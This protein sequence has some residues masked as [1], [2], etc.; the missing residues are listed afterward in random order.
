M[1]PAVYVLHQWGVEGMTGSLLWAVARFLNRRTMYQVLDIDV[2]MDMV[3]N[4]WF[5]QRH[6]NRRQLAKTIETHRVIE[7]GNQRLDF[8]RLGC[9]C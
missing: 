5:E 2:T 6:E 8:A 4:A 9:Q 1:Q 7:K 3:M